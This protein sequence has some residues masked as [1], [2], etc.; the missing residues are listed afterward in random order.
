MD[1]KFLCFNGT[2][3]YLYVM[4][5]RK[6]GEQVRVRLVDREFKQLPVLRGSD[7]DIEEVS[8]P[9]N[10]Q[11]MLMVAEKLAIDFPAC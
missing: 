1:Y 2:T 11:D 4:G 10:Y 7:A 6:A 8:E 3:E 9:Q 5:D